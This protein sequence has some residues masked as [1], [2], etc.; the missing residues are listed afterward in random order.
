MGQASPRI[1]RTVDR[2]GRLQGTAASGRHEHDME[3]VA[4]IGAGMGGLTCALALARAGRKVRVYEQAP[5]LAEVGAG[6]TVSPNAARVFIHLGLEEGLRRLGYVPPK[7]ITQNLAT[8]AILVERER[9]AAMEAQYGA[10]YTHLHRHDLHALL[11]EGLS[12]IDPDAIQL[13]HKLV[14]VSANA[15]Q[16]GLRFGNGETVRAGLVIGADGVKSLVRDRLFETQPPLFTGQVAWRGVLPVS[17]LPAEVQALPPGIWIGEKRLFMRY[18]MRGGSLINYAAFVNMEGWSEEGWSIPSTIAELR[19]H[20][21]DAEPHLLAMIEATPPDQ[22][23]KWALHAREPLESWIQ[24]CATLLGDAAHGMLPFM[25]QGAA[26]S[27][28]DG[29]VL[30]RCIAQFPRDEALRRYQDARLE[31]TTMIQTQSRLLGLQFQGKDPESFGKGPI[32]NE[33]T[34]GL[35][36]YD[37]VNC[38]I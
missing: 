12:A 26:T 32:Q 33:E 10:P 36:A 13:D 37:A 28:E 1:I 24:G 34:L 38:L 14:G 8:G 31:R 9:G 5:V 18:P 7:Q 20:Y 27:I 22:L 35:F 2:R 30:A 15:D 4:I 21:A 17:S 23:F 16:A 11:S 19:G 29:M 25:G 6:I 3:E